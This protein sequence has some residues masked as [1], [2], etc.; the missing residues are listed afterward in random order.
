MCLSLIFHENDE[1]QRFNNQ[2]R[3]KNCAKKVLFEMKQNK[4]KY[5][6][7]SNDDDDN[8]DNKNVTE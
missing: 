2:I 3:K 6:D 4:K 1:R 5:D 7:N 8:E